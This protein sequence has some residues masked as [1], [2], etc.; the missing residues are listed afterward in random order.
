MSNENRKLIRDVDRVKNSFVFPI[1]AAAGVGTLLFCAV[2]R[3]WTANRL[4]FENLLGSLLTGRVDA[5]GIGLV[6]FLFLAGL[7]AYAYTFIFRSARRSGVG[8][9]LQLSL[10]HYAINGV[11][12]GLFGAAGFFMTKMG[13]AT[14]VIFFSA[15][16]VYG[17]LVGQLFD[18]S[19]VRDEFPKP[20]THRNLEHA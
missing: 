3:L 5:D 13:F 11:A 1:G 12:V 16:L 17:I 2:A 15:H 4:D 7:S 14:S 8:V 19:A 6:S 20:L 9:G 10:F 18:W